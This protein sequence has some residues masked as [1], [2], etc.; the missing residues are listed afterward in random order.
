MALKDFDSQEAEFFPVALV[1]GYVAGE[2]CDWEAGEEIPCRA[3]LATIV[4]IL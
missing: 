4:K 1:E 2:S 3:S